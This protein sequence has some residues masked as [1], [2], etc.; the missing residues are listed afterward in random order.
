MHLQHMHL[1]T[2]RYSMSL[3]TLHRSVRTYDFAQYNT[4]YIRQLICHHFIHRLPGSGEDCS[5]NRCTVLPQTNKAL[6]EVICSRIN[7]INVIDNG[8]AGNSL[9]MYKYASYAKQHPLRG[10]SKGLVLPTH[11]QRHLGQW[12]WSQY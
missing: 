10:R 7:T 11:S 12:W 6:Y 4:L 9:H 1:T 8:G 5:Q 2:S 3:Y